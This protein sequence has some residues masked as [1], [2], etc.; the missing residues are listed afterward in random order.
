MDI[1]TEEVKS[2][3]GAEEV[4]VE[5]LVVVVGGLVVVV[6]VVVD[7]DDGDGDSDGE[8]EGEVVAGV[9]ISSSYKKKSY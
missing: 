8:G 3:F 6:A 5:D 9:A 2:G 7:M 4:V 1:A